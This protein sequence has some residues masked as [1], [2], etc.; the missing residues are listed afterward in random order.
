MYYTIFENFED[1]LP[2]LPWYANYCWFPL[3]LTADISSIPLNKLL[4]V[5]EKT[6]QTCK[7]VNCLGDMALLLRL[8]YMLIRYIV[9]TRPSTFYASLVGFLRV[10]CL[11][12]RSLH[13]HSIL[14]SLKARAI[15][16][17][18]EFFKQFMIFRL[19]Q[20][21][22]TF[23]RMI[24]EESRQYSISEKMNIMDEMYQRRENVWEV[25]WQGNRICLYVR[26]SQLEP[27]WS[28]NANFWNRL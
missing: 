14:L 22:R 21:A 10:I 28:H 13:C 6:E 16:K 25:G 15:A 7:Y 5:S 2:L 26:E 3:C 20:R 17:M 18:F 1:N 11:P 27:K 23:V 8:L 24:W 4:C 19:D 9:Y 12:I